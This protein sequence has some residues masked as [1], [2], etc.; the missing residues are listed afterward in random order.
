MFPASVRHPLVMLALGLLFLPWAIIAAGFTW[1]ITT[2]IAIL[3]MVGIGYNLLLGYTGLLSFGHGLFF[4]LAAY[5]VALTQT[6]WFKDSLLIPL[7]CGLLFSIVMGAVIGSLVLRRRGVYFSLLTLAFTA[8]CFYIVFRWT[9]LTG[10]ENGLS[11]VRRF[12]L[13]GLDL[14]DARVFYYAVAAVVFATAWLLWRVVHSPLGSVL[15]AIRENEQRSRFVGYPVA[16]YK[17]AAFTISATVTGLG[18]CLFAY[19][20]L[21]VSADLVHPTF[22]GEILAM[23]VLG[24]MGSFLGPTIGTVSY[25]MFHEV[26]S[27]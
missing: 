14:D 11:G 20:K 1:G 19:L 27:S 8:L 18:G 9:S 17:L 3:A 2:E 5:C 15:V 23:T 16:R 6:H 13:L 7:A 26:V 21:F 12:R 4:G 22:S 25:L 10:G 24:G